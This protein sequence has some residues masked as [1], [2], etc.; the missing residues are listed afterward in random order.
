MRFNAPSAGHNACRSTSPGRPYS[1]AGADQAIEVGGTTNLA[2][3]VTKAAADY[4]S[5]HP[6]VTIT[7]KGSSSGAGIAALKDHQI[8][9]AM[10]D[11]AVNDDDLS[12]TVL[13]VV[14]FA[15]VVNPD[16][17]VKNLTR[18]ELIGIFAGKI[19]NWKMIGG[20]DRKIVI[21]GRRDRHRHAVCL[22]RQGRQNDDSDQNRGQRDR[23]RKPPSRN[24]RC[25]RISRKRFPRTTI[26]TWSSRIKGSSR[27]R[28]TSATA[29]IRLRPTSICTRRRTRTARSPRSSNT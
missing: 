23:G 20:N 12:D 6:G 2:P 10:S 27:R 7:V 21:I 9:I 13:G 25:A 19:T 3:L 15:F 16:V 8:D 5:S 1:P 14:G 4:Q 18:D 28:T 24:L 29:C 11:V 17:G 22:R 26:K